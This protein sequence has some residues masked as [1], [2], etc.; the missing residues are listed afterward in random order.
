MWWGVGVGKT[1]GAISIAE[2][3]KSKVSD[4]FSLKKTLVITSG[5]TITTSWRK[6]IFD[7]LKEFED[8]E[9]ENRQCTGDSYSTEWRRLVREKAEKQKTIR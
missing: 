1:C 5:D 7:P 3:Y 9:T 6:Q 4:R 2:Q 8:E